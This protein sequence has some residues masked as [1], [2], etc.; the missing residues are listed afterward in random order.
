M[1]GLRAALDALRA[2][3]PGEA[4]G[5]AG[6]RSAREATATAAHGLGVALC[7]LHRAA[8]A[9]GL[10]KEALEARRGLLGQVGVRVGCGQRGVMSGV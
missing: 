1:P 2:L 3:P 10:L 8:E 6:C 9:E 4:R 7:A 5:Q